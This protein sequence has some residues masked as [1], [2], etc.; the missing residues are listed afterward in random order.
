[1]KNPNKFMVA[2][3]ALLA[4]LMYALKKPVPSVSAEAAEVIQAFIDQHGSSTSTPLRLKR[5][6]TPLLFPPEP[7]FGLNPA[8]ISAAEQAQKSWKPVETIPAVRLD[9]V[10]FRG[11]TF[12]D[13]SFDYYDIDQPIIVGSQALLGYAY[14]KSS[15]AVYH[16]AFLLRKNEEWKLQEDRAH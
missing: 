13:D 3:G 7:F 11:A 1:M 9:T 15:T 6:A 8:M 5:E 12:T 10:S 16:Q 4:M 14:T 2:L